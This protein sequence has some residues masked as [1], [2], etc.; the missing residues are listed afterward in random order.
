M[1]VTGH[2]SRG[3]RRFWLPGVI[4][5]MALASASCAHAD[6]AGELEV[7]A[8]FG[9][10][11]PGGGHLQLGAVNNQGRTIAAGRIGPRTH[12]TLTLPAGNYTVAVWL[13]GAVR[14][15]VYRDLC[16]ARAMVTAGRISK[17]TLSCEWH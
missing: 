14:L 10:R 11:V 5:G 7:T 4:A 2:P 17:V 8:S 9:G 6:H 1:V 16:S 3:I 15:T 12:K 13:P